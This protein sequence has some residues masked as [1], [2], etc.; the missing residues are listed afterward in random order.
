MRP[1]ICHGTGDVRIEMLAD[2]LVLSRHG[3]VFR[4]IATRSV[5]P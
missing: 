4:T 3:C 1:L 5:Q 2:P